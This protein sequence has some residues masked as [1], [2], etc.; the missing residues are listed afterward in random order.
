MEEIK[1]LAADRPAADFSPMPDAFAEPKEDKKIH[2]GNET[3][4]IR[5]AADELTETREA[6]E[7]P[8]VEHKYT[9]MVDGQDDG[10]RNR[11]G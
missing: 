4:A 10:K 5:G 8:I 6:A 9:T 3:D 2:D 11:V 7:L 1:E